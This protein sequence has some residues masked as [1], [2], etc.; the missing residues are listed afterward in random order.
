MPGNKFIEKSKTGT[1]FFWMGG[2]CGVGEPFSIPSSPTPSWNVC[3]NYNTTY[4][5][6]CTKIYAIFRNYTLR[7]LFRNETL[8]L[9]N[10]KMLTGIFWNNLLR[11]LI[12]KKI[13]DVSTLKIFLSIYLFICHSFI[14]Y[15]FFT[16][17]TTIYFN[18]FTMTYFSKH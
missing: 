4:I 12:I 2:F 10:Q 9:K 13:E 7:T 8:F 14:L 3:F 6:Y 15:L 18:N 16:T 5:G 11:T 17:T 1:F